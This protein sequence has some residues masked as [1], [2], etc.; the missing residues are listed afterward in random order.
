MTENEDKLLELVPKLLQELQE[1]V[2][3]AEKAGSSLPGTT[4]LIEEGEAVMQQVRPWQ[5]ELA[6]SGNDELAFPSLLTDQAS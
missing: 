1:F 2:D 3:D 6:D 5:N 4:A